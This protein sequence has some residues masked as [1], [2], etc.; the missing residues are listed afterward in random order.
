MLRKRKKIFG[1][2]QQGFSVYQYTADKTQDDI[3]ELALWDAL[4][5]WPAY[6]KLN[7]D[8]IFTEWYDTSYFNWSQI[9]PKDFEGFKLCLAEELLTLF[10]NNPDILEDELL[11]LLNEQMA[12]M[13]R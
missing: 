10:S 13:K 5:D 11:P 8:A 7:P 6:K 1:I 3:E 9:G 2:N 12:K 4:L